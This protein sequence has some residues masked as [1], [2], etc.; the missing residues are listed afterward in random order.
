MANN[1]EDNFKTSLIVALIAGLFVL[2]SGLAIY[3]L[4]RLAAHEDIFR[5]YEGRISKLEACVDCS[6]SVR[7]KNCKSPAIR[8]TN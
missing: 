6:K 2:F 4:N 1:S 7:V 8:T 3:L 5:A